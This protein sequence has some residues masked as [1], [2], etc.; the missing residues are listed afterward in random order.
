MG[1]GDWVKNI[2]HGK[3]VLRFKDGSFYKGDFENE[4]LTG[5][6]AAEVPLYLR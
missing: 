5:P 6:S 3:G 2:R 4:R 1:Q